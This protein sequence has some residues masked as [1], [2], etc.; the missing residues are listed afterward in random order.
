MFKL[1]ILGSLLARRRTSQLI[2]EFYADNNLNDF[3]LVN[4]KGK[5]LET[6]D[7][8]NLILIVSESLE[9]TFSN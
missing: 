5:P 2:D 7:K 9:S 1:D 6:L 4:K 8:P 3:K